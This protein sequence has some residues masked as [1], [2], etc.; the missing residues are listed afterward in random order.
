MNRV[1]QQWKKEPVLRERLL[2]Y[3]QIVLGCLIGGAAYPMFLVPNAIAPGGLTGVATILNALFGWPVGTVSLLMNV[4]LFL[5][6]W[7]SMGRVFALRSGVATVL[8][9]LC[10]D[11]IP[12]APVTL[13]PLLGTL[14]GGVLL[15]AGL[16]FIMRGG[17]T[18]GGT[19]MVARMV[20]HRLPFVTTGMFLMAIDC[21]VVLAAGLTMGTTEALYAFICIFCC[22]KVMDVVMMG[23]TGHKAC[24]VITE[25]WERVAHRILHD[26]D[27]GA[28]FLRAQG[29]YS[30]A[31]RPVIFCV[32]SR[33]EVAQLKR[34]VRQEDENAFLVITEAHE[35]LG[36]GFSKLDEG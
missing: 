20:H 31:D 24:F 17:A 19:D 22:S 6:G 7:R 5:V 13:D 11:L 32:V 10:I 16:G 15:G 18:T 28:T 3:A 34:I 23:F 35:A 9:S 27:R 25:A 26:M 33:Q 14:Y 36:E 1:W 30:R 4:P 8:F 21:L 29:A 12:A 2:S